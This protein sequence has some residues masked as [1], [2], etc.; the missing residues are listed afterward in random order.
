[1]AMRLETGIPG[2]DAISDGGI[3]RGRPLLVV[4][5]SGTGKTILAAQF[6]AAGATMFDETGV[7]VSFEEMPE[8]IVR[9]TQGFDWDLGGLIEAEEITVIDASPE[10]SPAADYDFESLVE[11]IQRAVAN[12]G[13]KRVV[14]DSIGAL[15]PHF[16]DPFTV[17]GGLRQLVEALRP[18]GVTTMITAE[19]SEEYGP[20]ARFEVEDFVIDGIVIL[21]HPLERRTRSRTIEVLK[22]RGASHHTG[23][24]PFTIRGGAGVE[25]LPRPRF[26]LKQVAASERVSTGNEKL[27]AVCGGGYFRDSMVL[28]SGATGTGKTLLSCAFADVAVRNGERALYFSFEESRNQLMR[29]AGSAGYDLAAHEEAGALRL[30]FRRPERMLL[31]ELLLEIRGIVNEFAP[32]RMVFDGLTALQRTSLPEA[33]RDFSVAVMS[34]FKER[35]ITVVFTDTSG[36][37]LET[38]TA[39]EDQIATMTDVVL[40][41]RYVESGGAARRGLLVLKMR[42]SEHLAGVQEYRITSDGIDI[43]GPLDGVAG[44][45]PDAP[46]APAVETDTPATG[47]G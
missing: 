33:F 23:E 3:V 13:A 43:V 14:L 40:L 19:R 9:N 7:F 25:V 28:V 2:F 41:L 26:E 27:D 47:T 42:G 38:K 36:T 29:N 46:T 12:A 32:T 45:I 20:V 4:G 30:E 44:F 15:F 10:A 39:T 1:M 18:L 35:E 6:L 5:T 37:T 24:F 11:S 17:R 34:F 22:L 21:R 8:D 31:E 16:K